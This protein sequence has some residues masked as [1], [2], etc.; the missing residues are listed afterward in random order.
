MSGTAATAAA[1]AADG[2]LQG[3]LQ[4]ILPIDD[5]DIGPVFLRERIRD[6]RRQISRRT[7][8]SNTQQQKQ[9]TDV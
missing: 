7:D 6:Q 8:E 9:Y 2:F 5:A 1:T 3:F 4:G